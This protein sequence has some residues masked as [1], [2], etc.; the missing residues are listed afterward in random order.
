M[1][2]K[3]QTWFDLHLMQYLGHCDSCLARL[4][5]EQEEGGDYRARCVAAVQEEQQ[6]RESQLTQHSVRGVS[7]DWEEF[8]APDTL[9]ALDPSLDQTP[10]PDLDPDLPSSPQLEESSALLR[11]LLDTPSK[12]FA[13]LTWPATREVRLSSEDLLGGGASSSSSPPS[14]S[15]VRGGG[16][17]SPALR[18]RPADLSTSYPDLLCTAAT[19][20]PRKTST[21]ELGAELP[22]LA[23]A[24]HSVWPGPRPNLSTSSGSLNQVHQLAWDAEQ[25]QEW[26]TQAQRRNSLS[27]SSA[28]E[29]TVSKA[30]TCTPEAAELSN[31]N[32]A[33]P[34]STDRRGEVAE[35]K[36]KTGGER[37]EAG[38][39]LEKVAA[40]VRS[41]PPPSS[42]HHNTV[43]D[44]SIDDSPVQQKM[45]SKFG[46]SLGRSLGSSQ[47]QAHQATVLDTSLDSS[48]SLSRCTSRLSELTAQLAARHPSLLYTAQPGPV[49]P[50]PADWQTLIPDTID[51]DE[52]ID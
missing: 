19:H 16:R 17:G 33:S 22:D 20:Q 30:G 25:G 43:L 47:G 46:S 52:D 13:R 44:S 42:V 38:S 41:L 6:L 12:T 34:A 35:G 28:L 39:G 10:S 2:N 3:N 49:C 31:N 45:Q 24:A 11:A 21:P 29:R 14:L 7:L 37:E 48:A 5:P 1:L 27:D 8:H 40:Y 15:P 50:F 26:G 51:N 9:P 32:M 36:A 4:C 23:G 18:P